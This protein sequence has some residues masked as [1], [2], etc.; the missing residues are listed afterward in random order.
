MKE[1]GTVISSFEGPSTRKFSFVINPNTIVRR[2]QFVQL[3]VPD[4]RLIGRVSD[5]TKTNRYFMRPD[6][7]KEYESGGKPMKDMFPVTD[8]EYLVADVV[9]L[10]VHTEDG[11]REASF[12]ASPGDRVFEPE[13]GILS[14]FFGLDPEGINIGEFAYHELDATINPTRLLQKH[15]AILALSGAGKSYL[16][17][18]L[19]EEL[20]NRKPEKGQ[21]AI[22]V[23]DPHGEYASFADDVNFS[24]R[25][26]VFSFRDMRI[27]LPG[28]SHHQIRGFIPRLT[29]PQARVLTRV[30]QGMRGG[31]KRYGLTDVVQA[32]EEDDNIKSGPK[33]VLTSVLSELAETGIFGL[34]DNPPIEELARQGGLSVIDLSGTTDMRKKHIIVN[35][36][37]RKLFNMRRRGMVPPFLLV[38]EEAHQ[39]VPEGARREDAVAKGILT[40]IAREGRK[41]HASLCL[42]S[43]R[44]VRLS[45]TI[46]SQC[47]TNIIMRITNPYDLDRIKESSEGITR[48]VVNKI[49]SLQVGTGLIVGEAVNFPL[50]INIRKRK[51][52]ESEKGAP[53]EQACVDFWDAKKQ[54]QKDAK[55]FM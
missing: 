11:F 39:F 3:T 9:P 32:I 35:H 1:Y 47:N 41:F 42:I 24:A 51:S 38:L 25:T 4:G 30:V 15:L 7:V 45:T 55:A 17:S 31:R 23:I 29:Y 14:R 19:F 6:S 16:V 53:L 8:W 36:I 12:P 18:V 52:K 40:T 2:G 48:G 22:I 20:L 28:L 43:Q 50:F 44:P 10:G 34:A 26:R 33:D 27:G 49:S 13:T 37:A 46:L 5:I 21:L 54:K